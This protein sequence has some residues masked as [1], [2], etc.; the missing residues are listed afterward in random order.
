MKSLLKIVVLLAITSP[1][2]AQFDSSICVKEII[3]YE[4]AMYQKINNENTVYVNYKTTAIDWEKNLASSEVKLYKNK[5]HV[6][7]FSKEGNLFKDSENMFLVL[8]AQKLI[9]ADKVTEEMSGMGYN[10]DFLELRKKFL[11]SSELVSCEITDSL[12]GIKQVV[13]RVKEDLEGI[14][15]IE[16]MSYQYNTKQKKV[17]STTVLYSNDY[18]IKKLMTTYLDVNPN[19]TYKFKRS[20]RYVLANNNKLLSKYNGFELIDNRKQ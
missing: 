5:E 7:F 4:D 20:T 2:F 14:V 18:K 6:H 13:L 3:A 9:V 17:V 10:D 8:P 19:S 16:E 1:L 12:Q 11:L 15:E